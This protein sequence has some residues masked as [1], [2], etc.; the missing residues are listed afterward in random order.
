M[1]HITFRKLS[2]SDLPFLKDMFYISLFSVKGEDAFPRDIIEKPHLAKYH[3]NW[4]KEG[5][6]GIVLQQ[7]EENIGAVWVRFFSK[8]NPGYGFV[9]ESAPEMGIALKKEFRGKGLG[10]KL[11]EQLFVDLKNNGISAISLSTDSRNP[12]MQLYSSCDFEEIDREGYSVRMYK[13]L[14]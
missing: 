11:I 1:S 8:E 9:E 6:Y 3:Q 4:G 2:P 10:R 12:A 14:E 7:D 5:D 13:K